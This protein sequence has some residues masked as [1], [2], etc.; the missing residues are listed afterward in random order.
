M[1]IAF[2]LVENLISMMMKDTSGRSYL[3]LHKSESDDRFESKEIRH[4]IYKQSSELGKSLASQVF[5]G[6]LFDS[7]GNK[8]GEYKIHQDV[9]M[10]EDCFKRMKM[11]KNCY[12]YE[13]KDRYFK[14]LNCFAATVAN[15]NPQFRKDS[16]KIFLSSHEEA[17]DMDPSIMHRFKIFEIEHQMELF[18][19][20]V[21]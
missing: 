8:F 12:D 6:V 19:K 11:P 9:I 15:E 21:A 17:K 10:V 13:E 20:K 2:S 5:P 4:Q 7:I 3:I 18:D 1:K 16:V 14:T